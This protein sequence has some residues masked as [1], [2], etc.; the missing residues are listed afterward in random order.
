MR[1]STDEMARKIEDNQD[2]D[3]DDYDGGVSWGP[4]AADGAVRAAAGRWKITFRLEIDRS[5]RPCSSWI[6][7]FI[8]IILLTSERI[9]GWEGSGLWFG[10]E[11]SHN[12]RAG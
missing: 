4:S 9:W 5:L 7:M 1:S 2:D 10:I 12:K 3:G 11:A 6:V 8:C